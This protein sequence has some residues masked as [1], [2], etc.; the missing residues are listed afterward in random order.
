MDKRIVFSSDAKFSITPGASSDSP[1]TLTG[2]AM[3]WNTKSS[4]RGGYKVALAPGSAKFDKSTF[5]LW[6]HDEKSPLARTD[7][8]TL[9]IENDAYGAKVSIALPNTTLGRDVAENV[10]SGL[11]QGMS[12]GMIRKGVKFSTA[13]DSD[14][15]IVDTFSEFRCDEV[16]VTQIPAFDATSIAH[17]G[18]PS[19]YAQE[20]ERENFSRVQAELGKESA[21]LELY[22]LNQYPA[23]L[24][25]L[26]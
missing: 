26:Q 9:K 12:F 13:K 15:D 20:V 16:T 22:K 4:D 3:V 7:N 21:R 2:Y 8:G 24:A 11:V 18:T 10:K 1:G 25:E 14:G 5:A 19:P 6:N 23:T 17:A